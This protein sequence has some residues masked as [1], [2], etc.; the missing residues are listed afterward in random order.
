MPETRLL[1]TSSNADLG[2]ALSKLREMWLPAPTHE[3]EAALATLATITIRSG[4]P[5]DEDYC[6][7]QMSAYVR[8]LQLY[9][10]DIALMVIDRWASSSKFW[11]S[12]CELEEKL[13]FW[14]RW[15]R[16]AL[17]AIEYATRN[18]FDA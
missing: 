10:G 4:Q 2:G 3:L 1:P 5:N 9:P 13:A 12:W 7:L 16:R 18:G 11:P 8:K 15:R 6:A 17:T 14:S